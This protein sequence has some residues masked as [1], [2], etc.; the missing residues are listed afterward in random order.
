MKKYFPYIV[1]AFFN[2]PFFAVSQNKISTANRITYPNRNYIF[3]H[4][5][6]NY[7]QLAYSFEIFPTLNSQ[8]DSMVLYAAALKGLSFKQFT[9]GYILLFYSISF[10]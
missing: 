6:N 9:N 5:K 8:Q 7:G 2:T 3:I 1:F 10:F 4:F